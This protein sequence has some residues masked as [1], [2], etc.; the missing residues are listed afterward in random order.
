MKK[1]IYFVL[2]IL[3]ILAV[4]FYLAKDL[5]IKFSIEKSVRA[6]IGLKLEIGSLRASTF[7][8]LIDIRDVRLCNPEGFAD[9][10]MFVMP[11]IY[12]DYDLPA[13]LRGTVHLEK[14][15][16]EMDEFVVVKNED[17]QNNVSF[18]KGIGKQKKEVAPPRKRETKVPKIQIDVLELK[19]GRVL[20]K[21]YSAGPEPSIKVFNLN[22]DERYENLDDA[23]TF[24]RLIVLRALR[25][26]TISKFISLDLKTIEG[27]LSGTVGKGITQG[28]VI[29]GETEKVFKKTAE[30]LSQTLKMLVPVSS[31]KEKSR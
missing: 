20:F 16:I 3:I 31:D 2:P 7:K 9:E 15:R 27:T 21:D 6:I 14:M 8:T 18:L 22:V 26:T 4:I 25:N 10:T 30:D 19:L 5:A 28:K 12:V 24:I 13:A 1:S 17:G 29:L 11:S 23:Y